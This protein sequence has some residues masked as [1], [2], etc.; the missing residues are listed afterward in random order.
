MRAKQ[1]LLLL[2]FTPWSAIRGLQVVAKENFAALRNEIVMVNQDKRSGA[3]V[4]LGDLK[5][6]NN[7]AA[8]AEL[9][10]SC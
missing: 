9:F 6:E 1:S 4:R 5:K 2:Q 8:N 7:E 10:N 3:T